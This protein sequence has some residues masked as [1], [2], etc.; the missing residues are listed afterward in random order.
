MR[1][2]TYKHRL[3]YRIFTYFFVLQPFDAATLQNLAM[4]EVTADSIA[5]V[6]RSHDGWVIERSYAPQDATRVARFK[7][8]GWILVPTA[9]FSVFLWLRLLNLC[10]V[11]LLNARGEACSIRPRPYSFFASQFYY[12]I[13][14]RYRRL[15]D[16]LLEVIYGKR[17]M[18]GWLAGFAIPLARLSRFFLDISARLLNLLLA[19]YVGGSGSLSSLKGGFLL[20]LIGFA[21]GVGLLLY[22][23]LVIPLLMVML[24]F[25]SLFFLVS[26][27]ITRK[28]KI[29]VGG[30]C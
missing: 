11:S 8:S 18:P 27:L 16:Y 22:A 15:R 29:Q 4:L 10:K 12:F 30:G 13:R 17:R 21:R 23:F 3:A 20:A 2:R 9:Y 5:W 1:Q 25:I 26:R 6:K 28:G 19:P 7:T 24:G 14:H